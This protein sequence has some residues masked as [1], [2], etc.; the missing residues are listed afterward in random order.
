MRFVSIAFALVIGGLAMP[1]LADDQPNAVDLKREG[2]AAMATLHYHEALALYDKAYAISHDPAILYNRA[3]AEQGLGDFPAALDALEE[4][5]RTAPDDLKRRVP[6]LA[7]LVADVRSHVALVVVNCAID[8]ATVFVDGKV[9][10]KTPLAAPLRVPMGEV[11]IAVEAP[12][13]VTFRQDVA[14]PG[15][16][17]TTVNATLAAEQTPAPVIQQLQPVPVPERTE[18][19]VP[20]GWRAAAF[21]MGG[22]G[23]VGLAGGGVFGGLVAA[24]TSTTNCVAKVCNPAGW[25]EINDA[26]TFATISTV[27]FIAGG[28]LLASAAAFLIFAPHA[29]RKVALAPIVGPA[30]LGVGGVL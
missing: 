26:K 9:A 8:G 17:L 29:T 11:A 2:D 6:K 14:A 21:T 25:Q 5:V 15:G 1:A 4:F 24:K 27:S 16:K 28:V 22:L 30:F 19:Y 10:G 13:H 20:A 7:D 3:R 12:G 18:R 23:I